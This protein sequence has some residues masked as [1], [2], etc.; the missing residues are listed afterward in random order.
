MMRYLLYL[1][2]ACLAGLEY[3]HHLSNGD[4]RHELPRATPRPHLHGH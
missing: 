2:L 4:A 3:F 1:L